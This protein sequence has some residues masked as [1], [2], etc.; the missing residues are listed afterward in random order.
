MIRDWVRV[1]ANV[2]M[3]GDVKTRP[4]ATTVFPLVSR[5]TVAGYDGQI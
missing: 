1:R 3:C 2:Y 5:Y 4:L